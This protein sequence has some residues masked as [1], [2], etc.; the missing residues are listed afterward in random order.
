[1]RRKWELF[2][3]GISLMPVFLIM[4]GL[5]GFDSCLMVG[6]LLLFPSMILVELLNRKIYTSHFTP[7]DP[8]EVQLQDYEVPLE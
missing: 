2:Q 3:D 6:V 8:H 1:M 5:S 4:L 7:P